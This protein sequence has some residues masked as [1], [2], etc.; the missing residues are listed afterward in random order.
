M[1]T[2]RILLACVIGLAALATR[3]GGEEP[4]PKR[5]LLIGID[6]LRFDALQASKTPHLDGLIDG[7]CYANNCLILGPRYRKSDT[8]SGPGWSSILTGVW[9]DKHGVH[10][11]K[12][13]GKNYE[14]FPHFFA[15]LKQQQP[16]LRTVSLV[17]WKPI[18]QHVVS[19]ADVNRAFEDKSK[20]YARFDALAADEA[21]NEMAK[22]DLTCMFFYVG[23]VDET[24]HKHGFHP[25]VVPYRE[26]I[27]RVDRHVGQVLT[28]M[29][30]RATYPQEDWLVAVTSDHGG[31]G[32][33]HGG[34]QEIPE[35]LNSLLIVSGNAAAGGAIAEQTYIV[36]AP[37]T[38]LVHLGVDLQ[39][40]WQLDGRA[41]GLKPPTR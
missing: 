9:A 37:V 16:D 15:R 24:G 39:P 32:T 23:Q 29:R 30:A 40:E 12:F 31:K 2:L 5:A 6:G 25:S 35:I 21:V 10:D 33:G 8:I 20:D 18:A 19:S 27:E 13:E 7:G 17:T 34:G 11:N 28:A 26:A 4:S 38:V 3:S 36:D 41:V 1:S 22:P 14:K